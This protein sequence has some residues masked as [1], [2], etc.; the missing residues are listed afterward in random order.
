MGASLSD[1]EL[2]HPVL[3]FAIARNGTTQAGE[4]CHGRKKIDDL[5][6]IDI[7]RVTLKNGEVHY[8]D[9]SASRKVDLDIHNLNGEMRNLRNV[10][11]KAENFRQRL[12]YQGFLSAKAR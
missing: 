8:K 11:D 7:N 3:T 1:I 6:P 12:M 5:M 2:D 10:Y 4:G 9:F